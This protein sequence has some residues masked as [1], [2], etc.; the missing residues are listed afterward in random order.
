M[1]VDMPGGNH[2]HYMTDVQIQVVHCT[3]SVGSHGKALWLKMNRKASVR[4][5][6]PACS[7]CLLPD[8]HSKTPATHYFWQTLQSSAKQAAVMPPNF[9][10]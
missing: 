4:H 7:S 5:P 8:V 3:L 6:E 9:F 2:T 1:C 10:N